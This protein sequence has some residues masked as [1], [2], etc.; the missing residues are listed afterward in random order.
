[1]SSQFVS[2][3]LIVGVDF[4]PYDENMIVVV[5]KQEDRLNVINTFKNSEAVELYEKL[6][7]PPEGE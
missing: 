3:V 2:D 6:I 1:M 4:T 7:K 5:R